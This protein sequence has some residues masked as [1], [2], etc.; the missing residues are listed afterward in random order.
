LAQ[1]ELDTAQLLLEEQQVFL[2]DIAF[3]AR[4][5]IAASPIDH[6]QD[7]LPG[8]EADPIMTVHPRDCSGG[9]SGRP[10]HVI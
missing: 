8:R 5:S 1:R 2:L 7:A 9:H 3:R 10:C 6:P 4:L